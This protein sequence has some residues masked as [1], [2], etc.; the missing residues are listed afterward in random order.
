[1][2]SYSGDVVYCGKHVYSTSAKMP[3]IEVSASRERGYPLAPNFGEFAG[4]NEHGI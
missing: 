4:V 1:M 3:L 2:V